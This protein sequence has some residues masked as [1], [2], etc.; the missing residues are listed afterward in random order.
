[1]YGNHEIGK[2]ITSY[3]RKSFMIVLIFSPVT[4]Y[5]LLFS[6]PQ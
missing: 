1:M 5:Y 2:G 4:K 3:R 6:P